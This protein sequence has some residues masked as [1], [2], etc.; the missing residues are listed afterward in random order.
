MKQFISI[1]LFVIISF[2]GSAQGTKQFYIVFETQDYAAKQFVN[3]KQDWKPEVPYKKYVRFV[4][5]PFEAPTELRDDNGLQTALSNQ[6]AEF[7][8]KNN[9]ALFEK[10]KRQNTSF[11]F[12]LRDYNERD[13]NISTK[14]CESCN[15]QY[16]KTIIEGF[17]FKSVKENSYSDYYKQMAEFITGEKFPY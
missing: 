17:N 1:C 16:E 15:Y 7:I 2:I 14:D 6:L 13:Y 11:N 4:T 5:T 9:L 12:S 10:L 8:F 3:G